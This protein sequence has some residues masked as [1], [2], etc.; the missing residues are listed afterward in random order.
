MV[1]IAEI[2]GN[3]S[4]V[5]LRPEQVIQIHYI[6]KLTNVNLTTGRFVAL[7]GEPSDQHPWGSRFWAGMDRALMDW[8]AVHNGW[9]SNLRQ[10]PVHFLLPAA[11]SKAN[12]SRP[13][14]SETLA[15]APPQ[16]YPA[17]AWGPVS[18]HYYIACYNILLHKSR[19]WKIHQSWLTF[20]H[21]TNDT[22]SEEEHFV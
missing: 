12:A 14:S 1:C 2:D 22:D 9:W 11:F 7:F 6:N 16:F 8:R 10:R 15:S 19:P 20:F 13:R 3:G 17:Y 18:E 4:E 21:D 5:E